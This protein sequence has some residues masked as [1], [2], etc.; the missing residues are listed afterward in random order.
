MFPAPPS[1]R[2]N[3]GLAMGASNK[4][5]CDHLCLALHAWQAA[6]VWGQCAMAPA[7]CVSSCLPRRVQGGLCKSLL[8][9]YPCSLHH[10]V[11]PSLCHMHSATMMLTEPRGR[12]SK[13]WAQASPSQQSK[14]E[15]AMGLGHWGGTRSRCFS[16][17]SSV[18]PHRRCL[19]HP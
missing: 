1:R 3:G 11:F 5:L 7:Q 14:E 10:W 2:V 4:A 15:E 18:L 6:E 9:A 16:L 12:G 13:R 17:T 8:T 19:C